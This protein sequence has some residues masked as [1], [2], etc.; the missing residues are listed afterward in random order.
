MGRI[1]LFTALA[2][3]TRASLYAQDYIVA[4]FKTRSHGFAGTT[5]P[6]RLFIPD[7]YNAEK[8]YPLVLALHGAG[9]RGSDS[10]THIRSY[11]LA[12]VWADPVNQAKYP[13]F[14]VA[15]QCPLNESWWDGFEAPISNELETVSDL[16]DSLLREFSI[17]EHR[18]YVT[19]LSMGGFAT[20]DLIL[21]F[22]D[23]FAAAVPMSAGG[24]ANRAAEIAHIPIWNFHGTLDDAVPV[25]FSREIIYALERAGQEVKYTHC[26]YRNCTGEPDSSIASAVKSH[27]NLLYTEYQNGGHVIWNE[28]YDHPHLLPWV[29]SQYLRIPHAIMLT[30]LNAQRVLSS[31]ES[32]QWQAINAT[33][34]VEIW[35]SP[36]AGENWNLVSPAEPNTGSYQWQ[37][38]RS[39]DCAFGVLKVF[40][41]DGEGRIYG[42]DRSSYFKINNAM[43]GTPYVKILNREF[44]LGQTFDQAT[45]PL[46]LLIGDAENAPL[47]IKL[48]YSPDSG[49]VFSQFDD[50]TT[51]PDTSSQIRTV[52]LASLPN[53]NGAVIKV[54][55]GDGNASAFDQTFY[56]YKKTPRLAGLRVNHVSGNSGA[57]VTP[58]IVN[59]LALTGHLYRITFPD[60]LV[61]TKVYDVLDVDTGVKVASR[62]APL[63]GLA[64]G[65]LFDGIRLLIK[66]LKQAEVDQEETGWRIGSSTLPVTIS[67]PTIDL[68]TQI[69]KGYATPADYTITIFDHLVDTSS[70]AYGAAAIP[71]KFLVKNLTDN[72]ALKVI[73]LDPGADQTL[74]QFDEVFMLEPDAQGEPRLTWALQFA[75]LP[76]AKL[77]VAGD[78]F[79]FKT[80][81]PIT[82]A[83]VYEFRATL[84]VVREDELAPMPSMPSLLPNYPNP[85]NPET[86]IR[87]YLPKA[88]HVKIALYDLLGKEIIILFEGNQA[89]GTHALPWAGQNEQG[90]LVNSGIYFCRLVTNGQSTARKLTLLR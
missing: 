20:W 79:F 4:K 52:D 56:F 49:R 14:V 11:R 55:T 23:R 80:L 70:T 86:V 64:E 34:S 67:L 85:F 43:N 50:F 46:Q 53:S 2:L 39:N 29:F 47:Q 74:S 72:R 13:C 15:P 5:L 48:Y 77:P 10:V 58:N 87:Y 8:R 12:T 42:Q 26:R 89:S 66:D 84:T 25:S 81:K 54:Q 22:P 3:C 9:E 76:T 41:K 62:A 71:M 27:A 90:E 38:A 37:T 40:L 69:L 18:L 73:F 68:G 16:L 60:S 35:H 7:N 44:D 1:L 31:T 57:V 75:G 36:D 83:D 19:G 78:E 24:D 17:D 51:L 82:L 45:F 65:P 6:Y 28:S 32:V 30:N 61:D 21:R 33:D 88:Q 59:A 63:D